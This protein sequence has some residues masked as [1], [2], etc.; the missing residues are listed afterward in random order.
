MKPILGFIGTGVMG[1]SMAGHLINAGYTV[2]IHNRTKAKAESLIQS[3]AIWQASPAALAPH[4]DIIFTIV[5]FPQDVEATYLGENGL[6][7]RS[8]KGTVLVDMT[9]SSPSLATRMAQEGEKIGIDVLDA[10]VSGGDIGAREARLSIMVG[11]GEEAFQKVMPCFEVMGKQITHM[12]KAGAGQ[13][14]KMCNQIAIASNMMGV[15]EALIYGEKSG[16]NPQL[17]LQAIGAGAAGSSSLANLAPRILKEDY[18]PGFYIKHFIKDMKIAID[19]AKE[20]GLTLPSLQLACSLYEELAKDGFE[21]DGTQAL[22]RWYRTQATR[23]K[24]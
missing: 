11:G 12:G 9:T 7:A 21:C 23:I 13:Y 22:I 18:A 4:C 19:S 6:L 14:T 3:G 16:L 2:H 15:C 1:K 24:Q 17:L 10:P 8:K 20:M 5:G